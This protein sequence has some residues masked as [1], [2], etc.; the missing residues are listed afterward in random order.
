MSNCARCLEHGKGTTQN[1]VEALKWYKKAWKSGY[2]KSEDEYNYLLREM[3][4]E[5]KNVVED[6]DIFFDIFLNFN[7]KMIETMLI[8]V[9]NNQRKYHIYKC[10]KLYEDGSLQDFH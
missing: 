7:I 2:K 3:Q 4:N 9:M 1:K 6:D 8:L 5:G 10:I